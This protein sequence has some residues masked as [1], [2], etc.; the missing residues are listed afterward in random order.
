MDPLLHI[1]L[2]FCSIFLYCFL[3]KRE[4]N[5]KLLYLIPFLVLPDFDYLFK[6]P[7]RTITHSLFFVSWFFILGFILYLFFK[8]RKILYYTKFIVLF[9]FL[10]LYLDLEHGVSLFY[11][12]FEKKFA[13]VFFLRNNFEL[14]FKFGFFD[15]FLPSVTGSH[16]ICTQSLLISLL[17]LFPFIL[18]FVKKIEFKKLFN[19]KKK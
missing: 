6:I 18:F 10:H 12:F 1:I 3:F 5:Y 16:F 13:F 2:P 19:K 8:N 7:H 15:N 9:L 11:P 4:F 14:V 17:L